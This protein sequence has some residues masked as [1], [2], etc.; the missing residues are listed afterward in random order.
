ML[1][2]GIKLPGAATEFNQ[3]IIEAIALKFK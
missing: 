1:A 3:Q 2:T